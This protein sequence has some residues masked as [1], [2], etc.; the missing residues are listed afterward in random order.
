[1]QPS[2]TQ[3]RQLLHPENLEQ[4]K[5]EKQLSL[6]PAYTSH[7]DALATV[8]N[9]G[10]GL[11]FAASLGNSERMTKVDPSG[12]IVIGNCPLS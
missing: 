1:M 7:S 10:I 11:V 6:Q 9:S 5:E 8:S 12:S 3:L 4:W 2:R